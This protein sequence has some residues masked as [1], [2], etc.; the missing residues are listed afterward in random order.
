MNDHGI[1]YLSSTS[2]STS[3][4]TSV[5]ST[6]SSSSSSG[7]QQQQASSEIGGDLDAAGSQDNDTSDEMQDAL[8]KENPEN[9]DC[10]NNNN[11]NINLTKNSSRSSSSSTLTKMSTIE[12]KKNINKINIHSS[13]NNLT[14]NEKVSSIIV[15]SSTASNITSSSSASTS[16]ICDSEEEEEAD[17]DGNDA[18]CVNNMITINNVKNNDENEETRSFNDLSKSKMFEK[19]NEDY[20]AQIENIADR[21]TSLISEGS[22]FN[23]GLYQ[24]ISFI[25]VSIAWTIGN[26]WYAYVSVFS[27][28]TPEHECDI[29]SMVNVTRHAN[30]S[31]CYATDINTNETVKCTKWIYDSSQMISTIITEYDFVCEKNYY[32]EVAYTI[33]QFG[34][35]LG[36]LIFS[37]VADIIGRK[38][39]LVGVLFSMAIVGLFQYFI[40]DFVTYMIMGFILNSLACVINFPLN[41]NTSFYYL[42]VVLFSKGLEA[43]CVTLVLEMF[44]TSKRTIFGIGIEVVWVLVLASMSPMAYAIKTWREIRLVIF[45]V[46]TVLAL[47]SYWLVEESLRW[48]IS[49][50]KLSNVNSI[51]DRIARY[52]MLSRKHN[53]KSKRYFKKDLN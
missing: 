9:E 5:S 31:Q 41:Y 21:A 20:D 16:S 11:K 14:S 18:N 32:F 27:G 46:L 30:D 35:I 24:F 10:I 38:P 51:I 25:F 34:Y 42:F 48:L 50:S 17:D 53:I 26:G 47:S 2:S 40:I 36:T 7:Q 19:F 15:L 8:I 28:F 1:S 44:S 52:N 13:D 12:I 6:S 39:V 45:I 43:V 37:F 22:F 29:N 3:S 33:E 49:M 4:T 23:C